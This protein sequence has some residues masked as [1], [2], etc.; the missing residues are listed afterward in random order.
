MIE[1]LV[2]I[3]I[4][5]I[6]LS[7]AI[8]SFTNTIRNTRLT[9][10]IN[11]LVTSFNIARSEAIKRGIPVTVRKT[12]TNW[13]SGWSIFTDLDGDGVKENN[14]ALDDDIDI[15]VYQALPNNLTLRSTGI[16][17]I[18]YQP[19]GLSGNG[20]FVLCDNADGNNLPETNTSKVISINTVG[21]ARVASD[22]NN[23]GIPE[24]DDGTGTLVDITSCTVS[25]F[26]S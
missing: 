3:A 15:R 17:R 12:G 20:S 4:V 9:T 14:G 16:N 23:N 26:T 7:I 25:P 19:T 21:R 11:E 24:K 18:T 6:V 8:P 13:E 10:N 1:L 22:S 5:G 2:T